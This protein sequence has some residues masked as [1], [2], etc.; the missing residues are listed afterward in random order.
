MK[1][2]PILLLADDSGEGP[3]GEMID[4]VLRRHWEQADGRVAATYFSDLQPEHLAHAAVVVLLRTAI[5]GHPLDEPAR[6]VEKSAWL[7]DFVEQG[8]GL[9]ILFTECYGKS[10]GTLNDLTAPW[11]LRFSFNRLIPAPGVTVER[12][13]RFFE[14]V[15]LPAN[16]VGNPFYRRHG[17]LGLITEG[18]HGTQ[19]LTCVG[20]ARWKPV[21]RGAPFMRSEPYHGAYAHGSPGPID[22]PVLAACAE[23]GRGRVVAFPG[24]APFWIVNP[25]IWR[26]GGAL[27]DQRGGAG[28][29][30][31]T[32][33]LAWLGATPRNR[34]LP[35]DAAE[36]LIRAA[37][38]KKLVKPGLFS[39][40]RVDEAQQ[41]RLA[42]ASSQRVWFGPHPRADLAAWAR[43]RG[44]CTALFPLVV[45][46]EL[47]AASWPDFLEQG[48]R[49][50]TA[51]QVVLPGYVLL[52]GEGVLSA[53]VSP[54][55]RPEHELQY[56]N[57]TL[58]EHVWIPLGDCLSILRTPL[59]NRIPAQRYGGYNL[60]E[61]EPG[62]AWFRLFAQ[63]VASKYFIAPVAVADEAG[64]AAA[65]TRV[66]VPPGSSA[67]F[68]LRRNRHASY[69]TEGPRL[70]VFTWQGPGLTDD[71]WE[72]YWYAYRP[73]EKA[74]ALL[75]IA[76]DAPLE[77][78]VV[79]DGADVLRTFHPGLASFSVRLRLTLWR[80]RALHV[81][82][83]DASGRRLLAT[84]PLYT[85]NLEFWGHVGSDQMNNYVNALAPSPRGF[86]GVRGELYDMFGFVTLGAGWGDY[87]RITPAMRYSDFMP[88]QE[89]SLVIGS[90]NV[91]H[92]SALIG[93][94]GSRH[95]LN[96]HRRVFAYCGADAQW[97]RGRVV[98]EHVDND[99]GVVEAWH[100]KNCRP[101][102]LHRRISGA[103]G[104]DDYIVWR[105]QAGEVIHVEVR[106]RFRVD[107][108]LLSDEW[109]T[110]ASNTHH[111]LPGLVAGSGSQRVNAS[112]LAATSIKLAPH[113]EW[114]NSHYVREGVVPGGF[115]LPCDATG[116][117]SIG[118]G[119]IGTFFLIPLGEERACRCLLFRTD[120]EL[121]VYFQCRLK[122]EERLSGF[123]SVAYLLAVDGS[124]QGDQALAGLLAH[125][126]SAGRQFSSRIDLRGATSAVIDLDEMFPD[127]RGQ[128]L[129]LEAT[130]QPEACM[131][132]QDG[133]GRTCFA[134]QPMAGRSFH[135]IPADAP[136]R[137]HVHV[138]HDL[139]TEV[140]T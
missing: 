82:A 130:G 21:L 87:L 32:D 8:G 64:D 24:S 88:R 7:R 136:R 51:D 26:F 47:N 78:V 128:P 124:E 103:E 123:I 42:A 15:I 54:E 81:T 120:R 11:G 4:P 111:L 40:H 118:H 121:R 5:P 102:R 75:R 6:F 28:A 86:L 61:W 69:V 95:Y 52:D 3:L 127:K 56:P 76:A 105:W 98:G 68:E 65:Q 83:R 126:A 114:D 93:R 73:G 33:A 50:S 31:F 70:E 27:L 129:W 18:G 58:L 36:R 77:E 20:D 139:E 90:F 38:P 37:D 99:E 113:K 134:S 96:D 22:D 41:A 116:A 122:P 57:S 137:Y 85:R 112:E 140:G 10:E 16:I 43:R 60:I 115:V 107:P 13:P 119:G 35:V 62:E 46:G 1:L 100:G 89:I 44:D 23:V 91:H 14:G 48:R 34:A 59:R 92:P 106:K 9:L 97:F 55:T 104:E 30:F 25:F 135:R 39:F 45:Y 2:L 80:D 84:Y 125:I 94:P 53:V 29:Q 101:T 71:D 67:L 138:V 63:L 74:T 19:H 108:A 110:F 109:L 131:S 49:A 117:V 72:G 17:E 12:F 79:Y 66:V 133:Q 132:W